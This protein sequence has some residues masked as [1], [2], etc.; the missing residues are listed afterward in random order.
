MITH[1][2]VL[3]YLIQTYHNYQL[4]KQ[5]F[6]ETGDYF[7][8]EDRKTVSPRDLP[9][10]FDPVDPVFLDRNQLQKFCKE[11]QSLPELIEKIKEM[12]T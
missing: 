6:I 10:S 5:D 11:S 4:E 7:L 8:D 3:G 2:Y 9:T 12:I 1:R